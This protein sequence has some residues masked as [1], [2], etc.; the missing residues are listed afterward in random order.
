MKSVANK[1]KKTQR[2]VVREALF[3]GLLTR[4]LHDLPNKLNADNQF[5]ISAAAVEDAQ[6]KLGDSRYGLQLF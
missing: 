6:N 3:D 5:N 2:E 4:Q 1:L